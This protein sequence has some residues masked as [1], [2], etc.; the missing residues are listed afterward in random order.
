MLKESLE[1][2]ERSYFFYPF[3]TGSGVSSSCPPGSFCKLGNSGPQ[4]CP[5]NKYR[6]LKN[7]EN[8]TDCFP[9][10]AGYW[11]NLTGMASLVGYECPVGHYCLEG[12]SPTYC[13]AGNLRKS[14]GARNATDCQPC[15]SQYYCPDGIANIDGIPCRARR[16]CPQGSAVEWICPAG[17][18]C[19]AMTADPLI[20]PGT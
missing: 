3:F 18:Y 17:Y 5:T 13:P 14:V 19:P 2:I 1:Q 9:C 12:Q 15:P 11:C 4:E 6:N 8:I 20:C 10:P 7:G 16:Y